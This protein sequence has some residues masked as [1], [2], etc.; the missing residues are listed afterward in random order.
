[1][2][3]CPQ[4]VCSSIYSVKETVYAHIQP[5]HSQHTEGETPLEPS[6]FV[7]QTNQNLISTLAIY[8]NILYSKFSASVI[9][10]TSVLLIVLKIRVQSRLLCLCY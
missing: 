8:V 6:T 3:V 10:I 7:N 4:F 2:F 9:S 1:M 5:L